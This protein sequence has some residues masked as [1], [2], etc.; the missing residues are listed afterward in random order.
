MSEF[1]LDDL[2][3]VKNIPHA[4]CPGRIGHEGQITAI[5]KNRSSDEFGLLYTVLLDKQ[6]YAFWAHEIELIANDDE[7]FA[8]D[9]KP[10]RTIDQIMDVLFN[11]SYET[12]RKRHAKHTR[13]PRSEGPEAKAL[14]RIRAHLEK[15]CHARVL[16]TNAGYVKDQEGNVINLGEPGRS[17]LHALIPIV[18]NDFTFGI[19]MAIECKAGANKETPLQRKYLDNVK[20]KGG[21]AV[22]AYDVLDVDTAIAD[23]IAELRRVVQWRA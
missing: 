10:E 20:V 9:Y 3:R 21:I 6:L 17:A 4:S 19:F 15:H 23:K 13:K 16:R 5:D 1:N 22:V 8:D 7:L 11:E 18:I 14:N 12:V 2:V